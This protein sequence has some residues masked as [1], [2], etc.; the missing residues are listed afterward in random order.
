MSTAS[1]EIPKKNKDFYKDACL[2]RVLAFQI[3]LKYHKEEK[4]KG[5]EK[6]RQGNYD[7]Y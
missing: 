3:I 6:E 1:K 4:K 5:S 7:E 2:Y